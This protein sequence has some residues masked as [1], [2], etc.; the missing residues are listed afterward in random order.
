MS[1]LGICYTWEN[2]KKSEK[3]KN[4]KFKILA[5]RWNEKSNLPDASY[6]VS[7]IHNSFEYITKKHETL[8]DNPPI[9]I[10]VNK[11]ENIITFKIKKGTI[12]IFLLL[13][14]WNNLTENKITKNVKGNN[15]SYL[16]ITEEEVLD[17]FYQVVN[18]GYQH[19]SR[20]LHTF[21]SISLLSH[22][23]MWRK[24][25]TFCLLWNWLHH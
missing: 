2:I 14:R 15:L 10:Y 11:V 22:L 13:K 20:V 16:E 5:S 9:R 21:I 23:R 24:V 7:D 1:S 19:N 3:I 25:K 18:N 17:H 12:S 4:N 8:T 6:S